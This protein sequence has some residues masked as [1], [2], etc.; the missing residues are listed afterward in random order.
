L[1]RETSQT[2]ERLSALH[3]KLH[4]EAEKIRKWKTK[5]DLEL[6]DKTKKLQ[7]AN[8]TIDC[9]KK[10]I[11]ELQFQNEK[12]SSKLQEEIAGQIELEQKAVAT[13]ELTGEQDREELHY[14]EKQR[15]AQFQELVVKFQELEIQHSTKYNEMKDKLQKQHERH[16]AVIA[17]TTQNIHEKEKQITLLSEEKVEKDFK[18]SALV[19]DLGENRE[20]LEATKNDEA[21]LKDKLKKSESIITS[22]DINLKSDDNKK[23][24][25]QTC[26]KDRI[27]A[28]LQQEKLTLEQMLKE[29][30][31]QYILKA[32]T[33]QANIMQLT[34]EIDAHKARIK[35]LT[36]NVDMLTKELEHKEKDSD[37]LKNKTERLLKET[38][39]LKESNEKLT[40]YQEDLIKC[41]QK[42]NEFKTVQESS[43]QYIA[44]LEQEKSLVENLQMDLKETKKKEQML[45]EKIDKLEN[46]LREGSLN[47]DSITSDFEEIKAEKREL[48]KQLEQANK[49][50]EDMNLQIKVLLS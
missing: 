40:C 29:E 28:Q 10:S 48:Q 15:L 41:L 35:E 11:L 33:F 25:S 49:E 34:N 24:M 5:T 22:Q 20:H 27:L 38:E 6:N 47:Q 19:K 43:K 2:T 39:E 16:S 37:E 30:E 7:D 12:L 9:Q 13:R 26:E 23:L 36:D 21:A 50:I 17:E 31:K 44:E 32:E 18:I 3:N 42:E 14:S 45:Q 8:Q 1:E 4:Q 46:L